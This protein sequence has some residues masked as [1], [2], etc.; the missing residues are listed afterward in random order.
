[1]GRRVNIPQ[2]KSEPLT[3][4][5]I[6]QRLNYLFASW[7]YNVNGLYVF[8]WE[9]DKLIWMKSGYIYEF[10]I[11]VSRADYKN[12]FKHKKDKHIILQG[13]TDQEK[14]MPSC[15]QH[16]EWNKKNY[17]SLEDYLSGITPDSTSLIV[18]HKKP[19]YFYYAVPEGL[20]QLE[21]VP[22]YAGLI[23]IEK[24]YRYIRQSLVIKKQAPRLHKTKYKD[25]ELNLGEKFYYNWQSDRKLRI[26]AQKE[27][28]NIRKLLREELDRCHQGMT[29]GQLERLYETVREE[30]ND[31]QQKYYDLVT[32]QKTDRMM[33]HRMGKMLK[34]LNPDFSYLGL[35]EECEKILG[36]K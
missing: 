6:Q 31:Y 24:E 26:E 34:D 15:Y 17:A 14:Y 1:M 13:P 19:N 36:I 27:A 23:W 12:D 5:T 8:E 10:E 28:E 3:E 11:K 9:S 21:E 32:G 29:Y 20:I 4:Q 22:D 25:A 18:N 30:R 35:E 7:K 2:I 33:L 16:Y